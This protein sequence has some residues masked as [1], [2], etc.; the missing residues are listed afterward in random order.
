[1]AQREDLE[2]QLAALTSLVEALTAMKE[3]HREPMSA[4]C[5]SILAAL[6]DAPDPLVRVSDAADNPFVAASRKHRKWLCC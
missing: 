3:M 4:A 6:E 5:D 1:M 2:E